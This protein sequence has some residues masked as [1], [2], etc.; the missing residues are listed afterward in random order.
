M[1]DQE[2]EIDKIKGQLKSL[3]LRIRR[4][5]SALAYSGPGNKKDREQAG[6]AA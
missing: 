6:D 5:E 2:S 1:A 4:L 3:E